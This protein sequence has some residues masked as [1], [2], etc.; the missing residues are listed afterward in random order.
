METYSCILARRSPWTEE[1]SGPQSMGSQNVGHDSATNTHTS[2][3]DRYTAL[4]GNWEREGCGALHDQEV[5]W[6]EV[7]GAPGQRPEAG[8]HAEPSPGSHP[9]PHLPFRP[10]L[11][12]ALTEHIFSAVS[13]L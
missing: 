10:S 4:P 5:G 13:V 1:H 11:G 3:T 12:S 8:L 6:R 9:C 7:S 2:S